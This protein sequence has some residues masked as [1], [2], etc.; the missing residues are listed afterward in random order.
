MTRLIATELFKFRT[1]RFTWGLVAGAVVLAGL[2]TLL[3]ISVFERLLPGLDLGSEAGLHSLLANGANGSI[4]MVVMGIV[5]V[6]G[7]YRHGTIAHTFLVTPVRGRVIVAKAI[8]TAVTGMAVGVVT[9]LVSVAV[10]LTWLA[11]HA[12]PVQLSAPSMVLFLLGGVLGTALSGAFG[13]GLGALLRGQVAAIVVAVVVE[14]LL[15]PLIA[16][17]IPTLGKYLPTSS[18]GAVIGRAGSNLLPVWGGG[19]VYVLYVVVLVRAGILVTNRRPI[20]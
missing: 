11:T 13:V 8:A 17:W 9:A 6:G 10:T 4:L 5:A 20:T 12:I 7:E 1:T 2:G 18:L 14:P 19:L 15:E 3:N 16:Q